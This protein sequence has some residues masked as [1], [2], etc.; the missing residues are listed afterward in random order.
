MTYIDYLNDFN[1]W[2][3]SNTLPGNA[4]LLYF[5]LL[6]VFNR[7]G[8][9]EQ[10]RVD[11]LRLMQM[12]DSMDK[13]TVYRARD[14]LAEAGFITFE[15]GVKGKPTQ[16]TL[17]AIGRKN[18]TESGTQ[19]STKNGTKRST[20]CGTENGTHIKT[21]DKD[22]E[23]DNIPPK[24]PQGETPHLVGQAE[25]G[26]G[27]ELQAAFDQ[28]LAYKRERREGYKPTGLQSLMTQIRN[29][30]SQHGDSAVV[31]VIQQSMAS[32]YRG[33]VFDRLKSR[34]PEGIAPAS[35]V[36]PDYKNANKEWSL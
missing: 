25:T 18:P 21:L 14:K 33:I 30:A 16:F 5:K 4:Q 22:L 7:A 8:W 6:N 29:A 24:S 11:T 3:E 2:L 15:K 35:S 12:T 1:H 28:W 31:G 23:K 32:G 34:K 26:F 36:A 10:V 27:A 20:K 13:R 19:S 17:Q 9:P